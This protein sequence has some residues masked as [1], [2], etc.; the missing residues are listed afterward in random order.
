M[1]V[2]RAPLHFIYLV[3]LA[4]IWGS[5]FLFIKI[6]LDSVTPLTIAAGR[7]V[8]GAV[9]TTFIAIKMG[10][11]FP[12]DLG[13]WKQCGAIGITGNV[14]PFFVAGW[15]VQYVPSSLAAICM[16]L[17]PLFTLVL[18]HYMT[19]DEKFSANKL[20]GIMFGIVGVGSLFIGTMSD[21]ENPPLMYLALIGLLVTSFSYALSGV[22]I[23][24]LKNK[25]PLST[26]AMML[27]TSSIII[28]P[29]ALIFE[30]PWT[31]T[32]TS[33]ALYSVV[34]L[35]VFPTGFA[36]LSLLSFGAAHFY[37]SK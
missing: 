7:I 5:A 15:C 21:V 2:H 29:L 25:D 33:P 27:L 20:I 6:A 23:K 30:Q 26:S 14:V 22:M 13:Q 37:L 19:H 10:S 35:G 16:S 12:R 1:P 32:P 31:L 34:V 3:V 11:K 18:A 8:I 28:I 17:I 4:V 24:G 9:I 36:A